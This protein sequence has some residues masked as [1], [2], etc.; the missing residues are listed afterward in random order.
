[1]PAFMAGHSLGEY[2]ALVCAQAM[3]FADAVRLVA[4]RARFM[5]EA[6]APG[7]GAMAAIIG[8]DD[9]GV[10]KLC[11][12]NAAGEVLEPVNY[13]APGQVVIA[14]TAA[15][16]A[17]AAE[18]A[19]DA[20]AKRAIVLPVSVPSHCAL[21]RGA[22]DRLA[23]RLAQITVSEP[24]IPVLHNVHVSA[25]RDPDAIRRALAQQLYSPV[26]WVETISHICAQGVGL[27]IECGPGKVLS[28]LNKRIDRD[29]ATLPVF[30]R[31][32]L[33]QALEAAA[34]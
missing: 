14:G 32:S 24:R 26:R 29:S 3:E 31:A 20:G 28:G 34:G 15:A 27:L 12:D 1:M 2:S 13:N 33:E 21:M 10:R 4:D 11:A 6:V 30:D 8:L 25:E 19:R 22:A 9:E 23:E 17:R 18:Q 7:E 16:V 5:Q